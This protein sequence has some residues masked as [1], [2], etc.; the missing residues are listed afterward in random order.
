[1][2]TLVRFII[3]FL[4]TAPLILNDTLRTRLADALSLLVAWLPLW[5][6]TWRPLQAEA[7]A[8]EARGDHARRSI[9]RKA[10]L[11]LA[12][13]AG[14]MG[15]MVSAVALL[16]QLLKS[17]LGVAPGVDFLPS[18]LNDLQRM[19]LFGVL[20]AYHLVALRHDGIV[21]AKSLM[22]KQSR[23]KVLV[24]EAG[25]GFGDRIRAALQRIAP[26]VAVTISTADRPQERFDALIL[27]GHA[28]LQAPP[29]IRS[30]RGTRIIVP[31]ESPGVLWA[32]G[33]SREAFLH[34]A[35]M[36]R[37]LAE[38]QEIRPRMERGTGWM[39]LVYVAAALFG[40]QLVAGLLGL[41]FASL[42]NR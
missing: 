12:L 42:M 19:V 21:A 24:L 16:F 27:S 13:F 36:V 8:A 35:Q 26:G 32:G 31:Q 34:A 33:V 23:F 6:L 10:Y 20:L 14:V 2:V 38:G 41:I 11:Y 28:A 22:E 17:L 39:P 4:T 7:L 40:L 5:L 3:D 15:G 37:L 1:V 25:E 9:V 18:V 29:W 30:F